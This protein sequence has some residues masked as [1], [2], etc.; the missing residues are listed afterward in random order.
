MKITSF[1]W[2]FF[3][4]GV[5]S[6]LFF[7]AL[8]LAAL[9]VIADLGGEEATPFYESINRQ[10]DTRRLPLPAMPSAEQGEAGMLPVSTPELTVGEVSDRLLQLPGI[11]ALFLVG[12]DPVSRAWLAHNAAALA[13]H[14]A[15]GMVVNVMDMGALQALRN[16]VPGVQMVPA[17]GSE[18]AHRLDLDHYPVLITDTGLSQKVAQ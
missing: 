3:L 8:T 16:L 14:H 12:D 1:H 6:T 2:S 4:I 10:S 18:L 7:P 13:Q 9:H 17:A 5:L 15:V 11:G